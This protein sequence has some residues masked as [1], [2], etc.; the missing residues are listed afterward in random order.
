MQ[1]LEEENEDRIKCLMTEKHELERTKV[2]CSNFTRQRLPTKCLRKPLWTPSWN[3]HL[4]VGNAGL[5]HIILDKGKHFASKNLMI[6]NYYD[7]DKMY[8]V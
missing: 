6:L 7:N 8:E 4:V 5:Y 1:N 2:L 3:Q